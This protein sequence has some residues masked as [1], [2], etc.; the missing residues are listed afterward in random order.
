MVVD[1]AQELTAGGAPAAGSLAAQG[2]EIVLIGDPDAAVQTFRGPIQSF[3]A[4]RWRELGVGPTVVLGT[5]P[6]AHAS[7]WRPR[8]G[9]PS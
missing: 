8:R 3:L 9:W 4:D 1:D 2:V 6:P 5:Q 7:Q